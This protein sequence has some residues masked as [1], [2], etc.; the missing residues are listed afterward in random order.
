MCVYVSM[1]VHAHVCV[2]VS[3]CVR[4]CVCVV[5]VLL[6]VVYS[7]HSLFQPLPR[8]VSLRVWKSPE[9]ISECSAA[10]FGFRSSG[11]QSRGGQ[12]R[13]SISPNVYGS[14]KTGGSTTVDTLKYTTSTTTKCSRAW[15]QQR[16]WSGP[17]KITHIN[18]DPMHRHSE[19][20]QHQR[21]TV[22]GKLLGVIIYLQQLAGTFQMIST[23]TV[24]E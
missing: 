7:L 17:L 5:T 2:Y 14:C 13:G 15:I 22:T 16:A 9:V 10:C 6:Y 18:T 20:H 19:P 24:S 12:W 4:V 3:E 23:K 1:W 8:C 21:R 11:C